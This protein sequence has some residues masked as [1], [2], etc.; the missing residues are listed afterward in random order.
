VRKAGNRVRITAQLID[1]ATGGHVWAERWDRNLDDIFALQD[2]ISQAIVG[3]LRLRLLP[4]EKLA[5]ER[6]G[7][8][9][10]EAYDLYLMARRHFLGASSKRRDLVIRLCQGA[11]A[12]DATYARPWALMAFCSSIQSDSRPEMRAAAQAAT[13]RA[14]ALNPDLGEAH[15]AKGR[16]LI[17]V[18][19]F[20]EARAAL[21]TARRLAPDSGEV[22]RT[23]GTCAL[24]LRRFAEARDFFNAAA[25]IDEADGVS[26]FMSIQCC[27]ALGDAEGAR[28]AAREAVT[29]LEKATAAEPDNGSILAYGVGALILLGEFDRAK[30]WT[31]HALLIEPDDVTL[32]YNLACALSRSDDKVPALD[33]LEQCLKR[34][35]R[36]ILTWADADSD[37]DRLRQLPRFAEIMTAARARDATAAE[38]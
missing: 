24:G 34:G 3:A 6:R 5:I 19:R 15:A 28:T 31:R 12:L 26:L 9:N 37:L 22:N 18:G 29:R 11:I 20:E 33:L 36:P 30:D 32:L 35:G 13:E 7:T 23:A 16:L 38:S 17:D 8:E 25:V 4:E 27:E 2:E 1:G 14:L 10:V 21:A